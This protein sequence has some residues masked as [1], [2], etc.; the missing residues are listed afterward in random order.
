MSTDHTHPDDRP[1]NLWGTSI[2]GL[3]LAF[4]V[5]SGFVLMPVIQA[6]SGNRCLYRD[7]QGTRNFCGFSRRETTSVRCEGFT[8]FARGMD[9]ATVFDIQRGTGC[10]RRETAASVC[11][12]CHGETGVSADA[13]Q[14][15]QHGRPIVLRDLQAIARLQVGGRKSEVMQPIVADSDGRADADVSAFYARQQ[16]ARW[17]PTWGQTASPKIEVLVGE[18]GIPHAAFPACESCHNPTA[19]GPIETPVLFAQTKAYLAAQCAPIARA[20]RR[21]DLY[22]SHAKHRA[23]TFGRGNRWPRP[24]L[25]RTALT[26]SGLDAFVRRCAQFRDHAFLAFGLI[27]LQ[28]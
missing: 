19:G 12:S 6:I 9:A 7:L 8:C 23:Q 5:F 28:M 1:W 27:A 15:P 13:E 10:Q 18:G 14:F 24:V 16:P 20:K 2:V 11:M 3:I 25:F 22:G 4:A 21:N 26:A 17:D